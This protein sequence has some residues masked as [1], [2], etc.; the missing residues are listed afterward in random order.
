M[1]RLTRLVKAY[2]WTLAVEKTEK[3]T[4]VLQLKKRDID[5]AKQ[6]IARG[7]G[8]CEGMEIERAAIV[9]RRDAVSGL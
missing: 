4:A 7:Q 3:A 8:E 2:E 9:K 1:E 5:T 6:D